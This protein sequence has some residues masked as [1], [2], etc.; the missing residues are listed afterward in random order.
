MNFTKQ[1]VSA[2]QTMVR[3]DVVAT[4]WKNAQIAMILSVIPFMD[5]NSANYM[6]F[7]WA[8]V[9]WEGIGT[10]SHYTSHLYENAC[11]EFMDNARGAWNQEFNQLVYDYY[12]MP[13]VQD[14]VMTLS[15]AEFPALRMA[16]TMYAM[17]TYASITG[18]AELMR[19]AAAGQNVFTNI[20]SSLM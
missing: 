4:Q 10:F 5:L 9:D 19:L 13:E 12:M 2:L 11:E 14:A 20:Y 18:D 7:D 16:A 17:Q 1:I 3:K 15:E 8:S 6:D